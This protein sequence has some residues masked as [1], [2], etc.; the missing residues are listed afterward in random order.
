M[1]RNKPKLQ[2]CGITI[3]LSNPSRFDKTSLLTANASTLFNNYCLQ[4]DFNQ[5]Q[6]DVRVMEDK[7]E[8]LNG[9]RAV[10]LLGE[11][12]MHEWV[13]ATKGN[14][15]NEMRGSPLYIGEVPAIAS[16]FPQDAADRKGHEQ[17]LNEQSKEYAGEEGDNNEDDDEGDVKRFSTTKRRNYAFW[18]KKD[19]E[20]VKNLIRS[21]SIKWPIEESPEYILYPPSDVVINM[22]T[23]ARDETIDFDIETDY[24]DANLLC[25]SFTISGRVVYCVPVLNY[26]YKWAYPDLH[27]IMRALAIACSNNIVVAHNGAAFDFLVMA[28]KYSIAVLR[29]FDT[30]LAMHRCFPDIEKSLGHCVSLWTY[31]TFH[32]DEDSRAYRTKEQMMQKLLYCGKDVFTMRLVRL[33]IMKFASTIPGLT[34]SIALAQRS[35]VPYSTT[36]LQGILYSKQKLDAV[37]KENDE[38]MMQYLRMIKL[39]IGESGME[40]IWNGKK[41]VAAFP[42]SNPQCIRY[43]HELLGYGIQ[44][45]GKPDRETGERKP[46]LG[47]KAMY[48]LAIKHNN[49]VITLTLLYRQ[50]KRETGS[51][52][53]IPWKG[54]NGKIINRDKYGQTQP[55]LL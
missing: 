45:R 41:K 7:S 33:G 39:L 18:L 47:K 50:L 24:E 32:K 29:P 9:T 8:F 54:D 40:Q 4:P 36:T 5:M 48:R 1:L 14:N 11:A 3:I 28:F 49:P 17:A 34:D 38:W 31:Q 15:L 46:S 44:G 19:V 27:F 20:K 13:P 12:A 30:M 37:C 16:Y 55:Q 52:K 35:I 10:L 6:C 22:L 26:Y 2:Y 21:G 25:F 53:F 43:F 42:S 51:L 23:K